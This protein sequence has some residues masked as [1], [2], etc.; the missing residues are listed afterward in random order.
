MRNF[1]GTLWNS[2]QNI[3][4]IHW[5]IW[6]LYNIQ[7]LSV[8]RFKSSYVFLNPPMSILSIFFRV[9]SLALGQSYDCP[10]ARNAT[11]KNI[12]KQIT[13]IHEKQLE[14]RIPPATPWL[15]ILLVHI[16]SQVKTWHSQSYKFK[17]FAKTSNFEINWCVNIKWIRLVLLKIQSGHDSVDRCTDGWMDRWTRWNQY[18]PFQLCW[19]GGYNNVTTIRPCA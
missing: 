16:G 17:E 18:T 2:T 12:C 1:K 19:S 11:L 13:W 14:L 10:S 5:K 15:P 4:P 9:V 7:I 8:L 3:L 6:F